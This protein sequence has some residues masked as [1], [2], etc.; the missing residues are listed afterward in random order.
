MNK[1]KNK[2]IRG[3]AVYRDF[4]IRERGEKRK[5]VLLRLPRVTSQSRMLRP[6]V[7]CHN[8]PIFHESTPYAQ[9]FCPP[10]QLLVRGSWMFSNN[11]SLLFDPTINQSFMRQQKTRQKH[12][13][14]LELMHRKIRRW[15]TNL[16]SPKLVNFAAFYKRPRYTWGPIYGSRSE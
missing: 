3:D 5:Q 7:R 13:W 1:K 14:Q 6:F 8:K 15:Q 11:L 9:I 12:K 4:P 10:R 16:L 2:S